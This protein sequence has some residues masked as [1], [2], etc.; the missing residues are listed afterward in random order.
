MASVVSSGRSDAGASETSSTAEVLEFLCLFTHDL[1]RKQKRWQDGRLKYH[2]FNRRVM[3]YDDRGNYVGDMHWRRDWDFDEGEEI[4]LE[5][6]GVIV[7]VAECVARQQQDLSELIDKRAKEKEQRQALI[8][9]RPAR[10]TPAHTPLRVTPRNTA[11]QDHFQLRHRPLNQLLG[12]PTGHHGR[13]LVPDESPFE[14]RHD[15]GGSND[16]TD[17][18]R[19]SKR[20]RYEDTPPSKMGYAQSLFGASLTLSGAPASSAPLRRPVVA[21]VQTRREPSP[22]QEAGPRQQDESDAPTRTT[23]TMRPNRMTALRLDNM[24]R[25]RPAPAAP[26]EEGLFVSQEDHSDPVCE[27]SNRDDQRH[28]TEDS[29]TR[30]YGRS[31][32][33]TGPTTSEAAYSSKSLQITK[34]K[35]TLTSSIGK[36]SELL[37]NNKNA[38]SVRPRLTYSKKDKQTIILDGDD[39]DDGG[40]GDENEDGRKQRSD[41][42][43][44]PRSV[45][46]GSSKRAAPVAGEIHDNKRKKTTSVKKSVTDKGARQKPQNE[47]DPVT[48]QDEPMAELKIKSRQKRGLLVLS[49]KPKRAQRPTKSPSNQVAVEPMETRTTN[50]KSAVY[51]QS[52]PDDSDDDPFACPV[53]VIDTIL[54]RKNKSRD[55]GR[56]GLLSESHR[57]R[58]V[59]KQDQGEPAAVAAANSQAS[60]A[61]NRNQQEGQTLVSDSDYTLRSHHSHAA[62]RKENA[63][64]KEVK[65]KKSLEPP[66]PKGKAHIEVDSGKEDEEI[67]RYPRRRRTT[68]IPTEPVSS[69][70]SKPDEPESAAESADE[71][72]PQVPVGPRLAKLARKSIKSREVIGFVPSSSPVINIHKHAEPVPGHIPGES[73]LVAEESST[74][75]SSNTKDDITPPSPKVTVAEDHTGRTE[76]PE[77]MLPLSGLKDVVDPASLQQ[78]NGV[79][80]KTSLVVTSSDSNNATPGDGPS[81]LFTDKQAPGNVLTGHTSKVANKTSGNVPA[82]NAASATVRKHK[83]QMAQK[84][85]EPPLP[86]PDQAGCDDGSET[87]EFRAKGE[88]AM[89]PSHE[90]RVKDK[91][92]TDIAVSVPVPLDGSVKTKSPVDNSSTSVAT[93]RIVNPATRGRKAALKSHAAGQVPQSLLPAEPA[94]ARVVPRNRELSRHETT[95]SGAEERPKRKMTFPGFTSARAGGPWSREAHD[96]LETGRPV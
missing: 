68:R 48:I 42:S 9:S 2:T 5:R 50:D 54:P 91:R 71:E 65:A 95:G 90:S 10:P 61:K 53:P 35:G 69:D 84:I 63:Q 29:N 59:A 86:M 73:R 55:S 57:D 30:P 39:D 80:E 37:N 58:P 49:E 77:L 72:L 66:E 36:G 60:P 82:D 28:H 6:G 62:Q 46:G 21:K 8:A 67:S 70:E 18:S 44:P 87:K 47:P 23:H 27:T 3:V 13:A 88:T 45:I 92:Q 15:V 78:P 14:Q 22:P 38:T 79:S 12:T 51:Q 26:P 52:V 56:P 94:P 64:P 41:A 96:L 4:E 76:K 83:L 32:F 1:K 31:S 89:S 75:H 19:P 20:R 81:A 74:L 93:A 25:P 34:G 16:G 40:G 24:S 7:Q 85:K 11:Q 33:V 17:S 43:P